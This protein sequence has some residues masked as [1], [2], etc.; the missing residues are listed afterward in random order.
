M[1]AKQ[2]TT[3]ITSDIVRAFAEALDHGFTGSLNDFADSADGQAAAVALADQKTAAMRGERMGW[4]RAVARDF[5]VNG[6][7]TTYSKDRAIELRDYLAT[8]DF[9]ALTDPDTATEDTAPDT[10]DATE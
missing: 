10:A 9:D 6:K 5:K 2:N 8:V 1:A 3:E 4:A 7:L